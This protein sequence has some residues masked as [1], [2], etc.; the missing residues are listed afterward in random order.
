MTLSEDERKELI[1]YRLEQ[2]AET[3]ADVELLINNN[4]MRS[5]VNRMYYCMFY[6]LLALGLAHKFETSKHSQLLAWFNK[7]FVHTG[8]VEVSYGQIINDIFNNRTE[9]DYSS[10]I[11]FEK[12][13][14]M[15]MFENMKKFNAEIR[16]LL[17]TKVN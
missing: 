1:K 9:G 16:H 13:E 12:E 14:V 4:R 3:S 7:D 15:L 2:A 11:E 10:Y 8:K 17:D 6:S 5:A